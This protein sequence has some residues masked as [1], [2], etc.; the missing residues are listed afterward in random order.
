MKNR[1]YR[2][3]QLSSSQ[4]FFIFLAILILGVV[5]F[6]LGVSVGK[7]QTQI[8]KGAQIAAKE[9][10]EDQT[11]PP[12]EKSKESISKELASLQKATEEAQK[13]PTVSRERTLF[14]IQVGAFN[15]R[16]VAISFADTFNQRGYPAIVLDPFPSDRREMFRVRI[17]GYATREEAAEVRTKLQAETSRTTDYFIIRS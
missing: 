7:K 5:I 2:E 3:L 15:R 13:Q 17:G 12:A 10:V 8:M 9:K 6:L 1:D 11:S 16:E 4:L 14:Y